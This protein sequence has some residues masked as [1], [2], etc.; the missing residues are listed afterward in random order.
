MLIVREVTLLILIIPSKVHMDSWY[1]ES[2]LSIK[3]ILLLES[4]YLNDE[5][6]TK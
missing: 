5:L 6:A 2:L 4:K 3:L 1:R